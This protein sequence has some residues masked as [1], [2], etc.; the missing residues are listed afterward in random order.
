MIQAAQNISTG[1][2]DILRGDILALRRKPGEAIDIKEIEGMLRVSR[3]PVRDALIK[4]RADGLV[5]ILPQR[6]TYVSRIDLARVEEERFLRKNLELSV[7]PIFI[8]AAGDDAF[9]RLARLIER[10]KAALAEQ[11]YLKLQTEDDAFHGVFFRAAKKELCWQV[12]QTVSGHYKRIRM[13]SLWE[14]DI[15]FGVVEEHE[16]LLEAAKAK[17]EETLLTLARSHFAKLNVQERVLT[18]KYPDYFTGLLT[19]K[20]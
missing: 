18:Q 13:L 16:K 15:S 6:G 17:E 10:Q 8:K 11:D 3:A 1:V 9:A 19:W 7:L 2:Y 5:D 20:F 14:T 4:L 12:I